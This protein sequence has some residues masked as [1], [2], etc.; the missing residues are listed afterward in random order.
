MFASSAEPRLQPTSPK[1]VV[2][3]VVIGGPSK[4]QAKLGGSERRRFLEQT[5]GTCYPPR[6]SLS[7]PCDVES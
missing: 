4:T 7:R 5:L 1:G 6:Q 2:E 3:E